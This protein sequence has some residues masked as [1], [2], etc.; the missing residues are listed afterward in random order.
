M[1]QNPSLINYPDI[2]GTLTG[3]PRKTFE[4][5][6]C[7]ISSRPDRVPAGQTFEAILLIQSMVNTEVDV[8]VEMEL[9]DKDTNNK[10]GAFYS[11]T[12][13][14]LVGLQPAEVGY[15]KLP[16]QC[17][18]LT[19]PGEDY[20][21]RIKLQVKKLG[22]QTETVRS[23][24]GGGSVSTTTLSPEAQDELATLRELSFSVEDRGKRNQ[25][26]DTFAIMPPS[27][28]AAL[29]ELKPGWVS[30]WKIQD[31]LDE[32]I[33]VQ[34]VQPQL[35]TLIPQMRR[36]K[37]F[38]PLLETMQQLFKEARYPIHVAEAIFITKII[39]LVIEQAATR[40]TEA[41]TDKQMPWFAQMARL[42][43]EEP[44][45]AE[46]PA[47][48]FT[49]PL[50][51]ALIKDTVVYAFSMVST[52]TRE[53]FGSDEEIKQYA[54]SV[55]DSLT[56]GKQMNFARTY[57]PLL[58][59]GVIANNRV[60]MPREQVRDT[61]F[62]LHKVIEQRSKHRSESNAFI[63]DMMNTLIDRGLDQ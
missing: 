52:V 59:A 16:I 27:G 58:A 61:L 48:L 8:R 24:H 25:I 62:M 50:L 49:K 15:I 35:A 13:K 1:A 9:P 7:A 10:R 56:T 36:E 14:L 44:R 63:F 33:I 5:I 19:A 12:S 40:A 11:K 2:L 20:P 57:L 53:S 34:R 4:S 3:G 60:T 18:A 46:Q 30:L 47:H 39:V 55:A 29:R 51:P 45:L 26:E 54:E 22:R 38:K 43:Y 31:Y 42:I 21:L 41:D 32:S 28:I 37:V 6:Q 17:S 23:P